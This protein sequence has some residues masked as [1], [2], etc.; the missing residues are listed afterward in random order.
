MFI[1]GNKFISGIPHSL[2]I[3]P[4][5]L[6]KDL[7]QGHYLGITLH[8]MTRDLAQ[9]HSFFRNDMWGRSEQHT[10]DPP[11]RNSGLAGNGDGKI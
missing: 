8:V 9:V 1:S 11:L 10:A 2:R 3:T 5:V 7:A 6:P 4:H